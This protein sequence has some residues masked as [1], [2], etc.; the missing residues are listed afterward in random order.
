MGAVLYNMNVCGNASVGGKIII[1]L[2]TRL[3]RSFFGG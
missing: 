3:L 1:I 2:I